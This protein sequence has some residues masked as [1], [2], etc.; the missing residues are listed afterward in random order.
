MLLQNRRGKSK[1]T[2]KTGQFRIVWDAAFDT[3]TVSTA[4]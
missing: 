3:R 4:R 1:K 2:G